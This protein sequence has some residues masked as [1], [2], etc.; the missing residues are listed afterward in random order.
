MWGTSPCVL[1][2]VTYR[3][4][5]SYGQMGSLL[6]SGSRQT[7]FASQLMRYADL[8]SSTCIN[9]LHYPFSYLFRAPPVLVSPTSDTP[10]IITRTC[11]SSC[12]KSL[13]EMTMKKTFLPDVVQM[14]HESSGDNHPLDFPS[15]EFSVL[16]QIQKIAEA[17]VWHSYL[18]RYLLFTN[19]AFSV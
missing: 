4:D 11:I 2:V 9:L 16:D 18:H 3:M 12:I 13:A 14:P 17:K 10:V 5:L 15:P 7:L 19:V 1:Q 6:R 8:Y